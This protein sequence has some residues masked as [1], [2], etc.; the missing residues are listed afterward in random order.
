MSDSDY[1][2]VWL[3]VESD[4]LADDERDGEILNVH[5]KCTYINLEWEYSL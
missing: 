4:L 3:Q 1:Y 5:S 2:V